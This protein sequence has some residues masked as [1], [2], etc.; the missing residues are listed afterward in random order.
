MQCHKMIIGQM[1]ISLRFKPFKDISQNEDQSEWDPNDEKKQYNEAGIQSI[2][3]KFPHRQHAKI[4]YRISKI[5]SNLTNPHFNTVHVN[6]RHS[7]NYP[8]A[9]CMIWLYFWK[10]FH[11]GQTRGP[12]PWCLKEHLLVPPLNLESYTQKLSIRHIF[13]FPSTRF[14]SLPFF[15]AL[16]FL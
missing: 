8:I 13:H 15:V 5:C 6:C 1:K 4:F 7:I 12:K 2:V 16:F 11:A 10:K 14:C 9:L 3:W